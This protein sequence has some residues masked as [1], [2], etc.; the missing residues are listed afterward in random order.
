MKVTEP[1]AAEGDMAAVNVTLW[2]NVAGLGDTVNVVMV[3]E[4]VPD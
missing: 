2:P 3:T 4:A 1:V